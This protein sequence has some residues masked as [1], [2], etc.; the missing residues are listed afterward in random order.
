MNIQELRMLQALP[1]EVKI[2]KTE[3]RIREFYE[4]HGGDVY[5]SE[6][7]KD[8]AVVR[9]LVR[10][11]YPS[12]PVVTVNSGL[13]NPYNLEHLK[14]DTK[15]I[16]LKPLLTQ[17]EVIEKYGYPIV[18]K[19]VAKMIRRLQNPSEDNY[20]SRMLSLTGYTSA[21]RKSV[22]GKL[23]KKWKYLIDAPFKVSEQCC[24][25]VKHGPIDVFDKEN[26]VHGFT[27]EM[28]DEGWDRENAY[29]KTGCN[30][31]GTKSK[32]KPIGFWTEQDVLQFI[33]E[34]KI[35]IS[36]AY[37]EIAEDKNGKLKCSKEQRT[38]CMTCGF[39]CHLEEYPNRFQRMQ[40]EHPAMWN[41]CINILKYN[42]V[43]DYMGIPYKIDKFIF[44]KPQ[45]LNGE[46]YNQ[47]RICV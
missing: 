27:G 46:R 2:M 28:A 16:W 31:F 30:S 38:G 10:S 26:G 43:L 35:V 44:D 23:P 11:L 13:L 9:Y 47:I 18:S 22:Q 40:H 12:V 36:K 42:E 45:E 39:G 20:K 14:K 3:Q 29:L 24:Y 5:I 25:Y 34:N 4:H 6:E 1:L 19:K 8:S 21:G 33:K 37:G 17:R 32:S 7:G 15:R 41:Y